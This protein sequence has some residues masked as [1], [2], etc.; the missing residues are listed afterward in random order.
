MDFHIQVFVKCLFVNFLFEKLNL[1]VVI[2]QVLT[3]L[4]EK[5]F[6]EFY[7]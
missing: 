6:S 4:K 7:S 5:H 2:Q 3:G 1:N